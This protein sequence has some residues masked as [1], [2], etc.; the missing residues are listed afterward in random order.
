MG[1]GGQLMKY[2]S[3]GATLR[4]TI[5]Q[6]L[7]LF[8][9]RPETPETINA[10]IQ[11]KVIVS[12][13]MGAVSFI[14]TVM[15]IVSRNWIMCASTAILALCFL[16]SAVLSGLLKKRRASAVLMAIAVGVTFTLYALS[17]ENEGFAI[18]WIILVPPIALNALGLRIGTLLS[19]YFQVFLSLVFYT[20]LRSHFIGSYTGT[21]LV[22]FPVLY[23][24][25]FIAALLQAQCMEFYYRKTQRMAYTDLMTGLA[26]RSQF[27][28]YCEEIAAKR[29]M[30]GLQVIAI[31]INELKQA[32]DH[33]G[34][35]AG[36]EL[37]IGAASC[38]RSAF[39]G[40]YGICRTG[41][42][43]F[44]VFTYQ[45]CEQVKAQIAALR[46]L[47][48]EW[49]GLRISQLSLSIGHA[50]HEDHPCHNVLELLREADQCMY[51]DKD[52]YYDHCGRDHHR[53]STDA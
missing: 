47:A 27:V 36:D 4:D 32:N 1:G 35:D 3:T 16:S 42:D 31:D 14:L 26:N 23:L 24:A 38:I 44:I 15:N 45:P 21:F 41:G 10:D 49:K 6:G 40:A 17:G 5:R 12:L 28:M 29:K 2:P 43:E 13:L 34:H 37:I 33:V 7:A 52:A 18:L 25:V 48:Y 50:N 8:K 46:K 51:R 39:Q 20:P 11:L 30:D 22:R 53:R 19:A 9:P